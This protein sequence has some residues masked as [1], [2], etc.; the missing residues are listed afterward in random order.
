MAFG[1]LGFVR[2][3]K[4]YYIIFISDKKKVAK[5]GRHNIYKVKDIK[6]IPLFISNTS[7]KSRD[8]EEK[9]LQTFKEVNLSKGFYFS[10]TYDITHSL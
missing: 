2:F 9:Y 6:M 7:D 1:L 4:G 10:Y 5:F 3:T 8:L